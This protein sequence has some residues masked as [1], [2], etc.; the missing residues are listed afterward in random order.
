MVSLQ[1]FVEC[2]KII[3]WILWLLYK[4]LECDYG[5]CDYWSVIVVCCNL[6]FCHSCQL[7]A[8]IARKGDLVMSIIYIYNIY[9]QQVTGRS[10]YLRAYRSHT[11]LAILLLG[12]EISNLS[13]LWHVKYNNSSGCKLQ[14]GKFKHLWY[15]KDSSVCKLQTGKFKHLSQERYNS[16]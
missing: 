1:W 2:R 11:A 14:T 4:T 8:S 15:A 3:L 7:I 16:V 10:I 5:L 13:F 6:S 12:S 9:S